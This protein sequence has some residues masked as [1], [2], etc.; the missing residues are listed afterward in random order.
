[1]ITEMLANTV[2]ML[3]GHENPDTWLA[4]WVR[5]GEASSSGEFISEENALNC[6]AMKAAI[7]ILCET[8]ASLPIEVVRE[9]KSGGLTL[10]PDHPIAILLSHEPNPE[11]SRYTWKHTIQKDL[12]TWG[13]G[14][15]SIERSI[16]GNILA[17]WNRSAR[18]ER[19]KP[20]R[21][22]VDRQ[23]WY[24]VRNEFGQEE[25]PI[26][27][28]NMLHIPYFALDGLV[29]KSPVRMIRE[30]IGGNKAAERYANEMFRN[31][32]TP[33]GFLKHPGKLSPGV[34][35]R[36]KSEIAERANHNERHKTPILEEGISFEKASLNP[37]ETQMIEAR[38]FLVEEIARAY[39]IA[40]YLMQVLAAGST[41]DITELG[42]QF[43]IYTM[44]PWFELWTAEIDRKLLKPPFKSR[45]NPKVFLMGDYVQMA[46]YMRAGFSVGSLSVN[47]NR[48]IMGLNPIDDKNADEYWVPMNMV[49]LS[50][51]D[52]PQSQPNGEKPGG[53]HPGDGKTP[54]VPDPA[55]EADNGLAIPTA[56]DSLINARVAASEAVLDATLQRMAR[57]E[58]NAAL[59]AAKDPTTYQAKLDAFWGKHVVTLQE[60]I[61]PQVHAVLVAGDVDGV[62]PLAGEVSRI[63]AKHLE[64]KQDALLSASECKPAE[65]YDRVAAVVADWG[66]K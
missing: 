64:G 23:I 12:G 59:R 16:G 42:R 26:P 53:V 35:Q 65:L 3:S 18:P 43:I 9:E 10:I 7:G 6:P 33:Q 30:A 11:T 4:D 32:G 44:V 21:S 49:A 31:G 46:T 57:I 63:I 40:L 28:R 48:R 56:D 66:K 38:R 37:Q 51:A 62:Y 5:G 25:E 22:K 39:R 20:I 47:D 8:V 58:A 13:N 36:L 34:Y 29:G 55:K 14:Y 54:A 27:A 50:K 60:A 45:F 52:Q 61:T 17:L 15:A 2:R 19:T 24:Q 41:P 1:M